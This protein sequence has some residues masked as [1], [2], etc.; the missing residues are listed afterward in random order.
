MGRVK[1]KNIVPSGD[2]YNY[3]LEKGASD[4]HAK[5]ILANINAESGFNATAV[6]DSG[7]SAGISFNE[8]AEKGVI[9]IYKITSLTG[10]IYIGQA[11]CIKTRWRHYKT[12]SCK[13]QTRLLH[14]FNKYGVDTHHFEVLERCSIDVLNS[15]ERHWQ[16]VYEATGKNGLNCYLTDTTEKPRVFSEEVR[17]KISESKKGEKNPMF[18]RTG[19]QHPKFGIR[20]KDHPM[21][22]KTPSDETRE[23]IRQALKGRPLNPETVA[24]QVA[25]RIG[26]YTGKNSK[27]FGTK[28]SAETIEKI[29]LSKIGSKHSE[30]TKAYLRTLQC[31]GKSSKARKV[32]NTETQEIFECIKYAA[33]SVGISLKNLSRKLKGDRKNNTSFI[34]YTE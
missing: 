34:Y 4:A 26:K 24:K 20:G 33:E 13:Q 11:K 30:T 25:S 3:L 9:G 28:R 22:G 18:G 32:V 10:K 21:Y 15:R 17:Q 8:M 27:I 29:R 31:G 2:V 5:G 19:G 6:G 12:R 7:S 14:S 23:K 16:E 1:D